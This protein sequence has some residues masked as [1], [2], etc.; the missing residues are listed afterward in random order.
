MRIGYDPVDWI[1]VF[2]EHYPVGDSSES[3]NEISNSTQEG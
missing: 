3:G 2:P 1:K